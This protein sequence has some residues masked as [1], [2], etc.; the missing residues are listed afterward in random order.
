MY[1]TVCIPT[2][3]RQEKLK[4]TLQSLER[5]SYR[6]FEVIVIDDGSIDNTKNFV[7]EYL[8]KTTLNLRYICKDNGGKHTAHK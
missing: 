6:D 3:N 8:K 2:Y 5:Q 1:F 4:L 7:L